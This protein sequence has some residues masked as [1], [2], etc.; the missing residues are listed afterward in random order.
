MGTST[1][2]KDIPFEKFEAQWEGMLFKFARWNTGMEQEDVYQ[3]LRIL[4]FRA[5]GLFDPSKGAAFSTYLY[6]GCL[7]KVRNLE[8]RVKNIRSR[9]PP[10]MVS[11][12][13]TD[14]VCLGYSC[15]HVELETT[16]DV[17]ALEL[18]SDA[19]LEAR[20][21][22]ALVLRGETRRRDWTEF[23][24]TP[25]QIKVGVKELKGLLR[26]S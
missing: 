13:C 11:P 9:I 6:N 26:P 17:E 21:I 3:E 2:V 22:A 18:L 14:E 24:M 23:G 15:A 4:L 5:Q 25:E 10:A 1:A 12:L 20:W 8:G 7:N 16:D 19:S